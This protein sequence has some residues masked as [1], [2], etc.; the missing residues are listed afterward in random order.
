MMYKVKVFVTLRESVVDPAGAVATK[1][2]QDTGFPEV[3]EVR[4]GK[5]IELTVKKSEENI[6]EQIKAMCSSLLVNTVIE[7]YRYELEEVGAQ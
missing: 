5:Y 3:E 6:D 1:G 2:L 7:N 4:I